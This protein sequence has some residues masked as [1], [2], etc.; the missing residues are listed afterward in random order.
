MPGSSQDLPSGS[1]PVNLAS[2]TSQESPVS[3]ARSRTVRPGSGVIV[4]QLGQFA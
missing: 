3:V 1:V 4:P 2:V